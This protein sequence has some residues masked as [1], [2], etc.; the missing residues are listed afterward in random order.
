[1]APKADANRGQASLLRRQKPAPQPSPTTTKFRF[2]MVGAVHRTA[3]GR[4]RTGLA[5]AIAPTRRDFSYERVRSVHRAQRPADG[6]S[7][8][9][10]KAPA[11]FQGTG[12]HPGRET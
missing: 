11:D 5:R 4:V 2:K 8:V 1:K 9:V 3:R 6:W 10:A 12:G 7:S